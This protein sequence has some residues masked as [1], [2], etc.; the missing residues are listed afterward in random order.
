M[1]MDLFDLNK[2]FVFTTDKNG[3]LTGGRGEELIF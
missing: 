1:Y 3:C 2:D